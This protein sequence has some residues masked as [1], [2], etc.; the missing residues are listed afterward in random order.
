[1]EKYKQYLTRR[2]VVIG[3]IALVGLLLVG[4]LI[5]S[6]NSR[7]SHASELRLSAEQL[8]TQADS[9]LANTSAIA[10]EDK[11]L[12]ELLT[13]STLTP[14]DLV[15]AM[16]LLAQ[17]LD[18]AEVVGVEETETLTDGQALTA[19]NID[20]TTFSSNFDI[21]TT[22]VEVVAD[23]PRLIR[24]IDLARN[25]RVSGPLVGISKIRFSFNGNESV[26]TLHLVGIRFVPES[27]SPVTTI[28]GE[29]AIPGE[30]TIPSELMIAP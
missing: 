15:A 20:P 25:S 19:L 6:V 27:G 22:A 24:F 10:P 11:T 5:S 3:A 1:M 29:T 8:V 30:T 26:A 7:R 13:P 16:N 18:I 12:L 23:M 9:I 28:A 14:D 4:L 2:N 17:Q 21:V